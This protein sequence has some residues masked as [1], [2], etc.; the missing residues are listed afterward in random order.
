MKAKF[1]SINIINIHAPVDKIDHLLIDK[2]Q[3]SSLM[4][5]RSY[6]GIKI[7][8]DHY[9]VGCRIRARI[10]KA[11]MNKIAQQRINTDV[12]KL[13]ETLRRGF[14]LHASTG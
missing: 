5:V 7:E 3:M 11:K 4:D 2:H 1:C 13:K 12:G 6:R 8:T 10:C 14:V 9:L